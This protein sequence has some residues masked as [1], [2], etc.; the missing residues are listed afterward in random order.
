MTGELEALRSQ[1]EADIRKA[2][3]EEELVA[4]RIRYLGSLHPGTFFE[5]DGIRGNFDVIF[6][7]CIKLS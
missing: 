6:Q 1:A 2:G 4:I 5:G 7:R 3:T